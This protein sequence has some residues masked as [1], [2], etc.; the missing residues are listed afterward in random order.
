[1]PNG[2]APGGAGSSFSPKNT[3]TRQNLDIRTGNKLYTCLM[4]KSRTFDTIEI[5]SVYDGLSSYDA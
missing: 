2:A 1:M 5:G 3:R 4:R